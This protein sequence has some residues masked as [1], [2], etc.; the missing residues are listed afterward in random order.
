MEENKAPPTIESLP[1]E[2]LIEVFSYF[3]PKLTKVAALVCNR[4]N[5][6]SISNR[7]FFWNF[8]NKSETKNKKV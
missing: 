6:N 1:D 5:L 7:K 4:W 3:S 8:Q 2:V